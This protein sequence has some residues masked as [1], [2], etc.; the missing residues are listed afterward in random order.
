[1]KQ[2]YFLLFAL[3][4]ATNT[5]SNA[6]CAI[7]PQ[8][9]LPGLYPSPDSF[10]CF[11][12]GSC[13]QYTLQFVNF[14][15]TTVSGIRVRVDYI[16]IDSILNLPC[17][18]NWTTSAQNAATPHRFENQ[19]KGCITF[20]GL[21]NDPFGQYKLRIV[22]S[23]KV[24]LLPSA[25]PYTAEALGYRVDIRLVADNTI[26]PPVDTGAATLVA[27]CQSR[28]VDCYFDVPCFVCP[29]VS[30]INSINQFSFYPN[31]T[32][33]SATVSFTA[34]KA[35]AYTTRIVN[36][37]GQ[38]VSRWQL[39]VQQGANTHPIDVSALPAGVYFFTITDGK[40]FSSQRF[41]VE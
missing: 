12:A 37:Y 13:F 22:V 29:G 28:S 32:A 9:T 35:A 10:P 18:I 36:I 34:D 38:E 41:V 4:L 39:Q 6:Q 23:A 3:V 16:I 25:V 20:G 15:S 17:G 26:C 31:P 40:N 2:L 5:N 7:D 8:Y 24:S 33:N 11:V 21:S 27:S 19:E 1:M 14:D 30:E